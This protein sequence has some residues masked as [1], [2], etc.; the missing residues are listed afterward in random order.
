MLTAKS[1]AG[2]PPRLCDCAKRNDFNSRTLAGAEGHLA[3]VRNAATIGNPVAEMR[4][5]SNDGTR[6]HQRT[7]GLFSGPPPRR[8]TFDAGGGSF[9]FSFSRVLFGHAH[10]E[11]AP[12]EE[13]GKLAQLSLQRRDRPVYAAKSRPCR[14]T[15]RAL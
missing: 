8:Q 7:T 5:R 10:R 4:R 11:C 9:L 6:S 13:A 15:I 2:C 14:R 12:D 1:L 3:E